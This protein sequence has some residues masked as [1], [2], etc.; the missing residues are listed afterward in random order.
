MVPLEG[1]EK[2]L[3][4]EKSFGRKEMIT[5]R[6][7]RTRSDGSVMPPALDSDIVHCF[8]GLGVRPTWS[9]LSMRVFALDKLPDDTHLL[10]PHPLLTSQTTESYIYMDGRA[11]STC[12]PSAISVITPVPHKLNI[13]IKFLSL[14]RQNTLFHAKPLIRPNQLKQAS[15]LELLGRELRK[16][17]VHKRRP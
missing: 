11:L 8:V 1:V 17:E 15:R 13:Q 10:T 2:W 5:S 7:L 14:L 9:P 16:R 6:R 3:P 12:I 4:K